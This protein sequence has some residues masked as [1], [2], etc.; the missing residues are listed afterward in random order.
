M[1]IGMTVNKYGTEVSLHICDTCGDKFT[2]CPPSKDSLSWVNCL[3][4]S[5]KSYD[6]S[7]DADKFFNNDSDEIVFNIPILEGEQAE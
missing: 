6:R 3:S 5:C 2:V 4:E 1:Q 7:R